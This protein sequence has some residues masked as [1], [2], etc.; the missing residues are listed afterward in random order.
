MERK[1]G[2]IKTLSKSG[3]G[4]IR[5]DTN[6]RDLYFH[7]CDLMNG[8]FSYLKPGVRVNYLDVQT[9]KGRNAK[10][11]VISNRPNNNRKLN[12]I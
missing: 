2:I 8:S 7:A 9:A 6:E 4:H 1:S 10:C 5:Q 3:Y 12:F 11:V